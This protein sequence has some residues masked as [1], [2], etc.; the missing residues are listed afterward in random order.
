[1]RRLGDALKAAVSEGYEPSE[2]SAAR[3]ALMNENRRRVFE[4]LAWHPCATV[5]EVADALAVSDPTA[6][7]HLAKLVEA[8]YAQPVQAPSRSFCAAGLNLQEAEVS[9]LAALARGD[10]PRALALV[11]TTPGLTA[12]QLAAKMERRSARRVLQELADAGLLVAVV[13]GRFRR[14]YPGGAVSA[15]ERN[16]SRRLRDFRRRLLR[17]LEQDR[18]APELRMAPGDAVEIDLHFGDDRATLRL[19]TASLITGRLR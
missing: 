12:G 10:A 3:S 7:W 8:G 6:A 4:Y 17:R 5:G 14:F 9:V 18:L 19:P 13:D 1:V 11:L 15:I 16:A 2:G